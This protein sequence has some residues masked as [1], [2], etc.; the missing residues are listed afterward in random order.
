MHCEIAEW[1]IIWA[2]NHYDWLAVKV[3]NGDIEGA[4]YNLGQ[5]RLCLS[6]AMKSLNKALL[7]DGPHK[8]HVVALLTAAKNYSS[9]AE[10]SIIMAKFLRQ[11]SQIFC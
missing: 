6:T 2:K 7:I 5:I 3:E 4:T 9:V 8:V 1:L 10:G 11:K